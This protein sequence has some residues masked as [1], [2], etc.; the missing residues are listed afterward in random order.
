MTCTVAPP[1]GGATPIIPRILMGIRFP[2]R[3][4][5]H[6]FVTRN[7]WQNEPVRYTQLL[8]RHPQRPEKRYI[9][10]TMSNEKTWQGENERGARLYQHGRYAEA[11][12]AFRTALQEAEHFGPT[13]TRVALVLNNLASLCH[14]QAET[15]GSGGA[16]SARPG[17]PT[18]GLR[19]TT[20]SGSAKPQ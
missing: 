6:S 5:S 11:E 17:H 8:G 20:P 9:G 16:V 7:S 13:D 14:N 10:E 3:D 15:G 18:P 4:A 12:Q 19:P 2:P 1:A